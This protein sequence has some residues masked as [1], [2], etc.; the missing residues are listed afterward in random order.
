MSIFRIRFT[1]MVFKLSASFLFLILLTAIPIGWFSFSEQEKLTNA[2]VN[3]TNDAFANFI[4]SSVMKVLSQTRSQVEMV[5][6]HEDFQ[7]MEPSKML[8]RL[9]QLMRKD[10]LFYAAGVY[11]RSKTL[12][13]ETKTFVKVRNLERLFSTSLLH[14]YGMSLFENQDKPESGAEFRVLIHR[15]GEIHGVLIVQLNMRHIQ[16]DLN[17]AKVFM[18]YTNKFADIFILDEKNQV[19]SKSGSSPIVDLSHSHPSSTARSQAYTKN[20]QDYYGSYETPPWQVIFVPKG[21][22]YDQLKKFKTTFAQFILAYI[23]IAGLLGLYAA[24]RISQPLNRLVTSMEKISQG[25]LDT[26]VEVETSDEIGELSQKFED[27]RTNLQEYRSRLNKKIA[28]LQTL[29]HV[30]TIV[31]SQLE[32]SHLLKTILDTVTDVMEAEKGSIM[33]YDSNTELLKI[34]MAKGLD[35][36]VLRKTVLAS[37]ESVAGHVFQTRQPMLV[38]DTLQDETFIRL[39]RLKVSPG[40]MLSVPLV[41]K[42]RSLGVMN[43]SKSRPYSFDEVDLNLF[44]AIANICATAIDNARLYKLAITDEMTGLYL[45]RYF[46]VNMRDLIENSSEPFSLM[47]L[48]IDSFK[49]FNDNFG[50]ACGDRVLIQ[51]ARIIANS[52]RDCDIP[53]R[54]GGEEFAVICPGQT[55]KEAKAPSNRLRKLIHDKPVITPDGQEVQV[56]VSIGIAEYPKDG[57][58]VDAIY[59]ASDQALYR[60]KRE[61]KNCVTLYEPCTP[62][63]KKA[64]TV[65]NQEK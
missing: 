46:Y 18:E 40:T 26:V 5:A 63:T 12:V 10:A 54:L 32:Y 56:A 57:D 45:R 9:K 19:I 38:L 35:K 11:D 7:E 55:S 47:M 50:H 42:E 15:G 60:S 27:M 52:V 48:D 37:G 33:I 62:N 8:S 34:A 13:A 29:Y 58:T 3:K 14:R 24:R 61:G 44:Q 22:A 4:A 51:V 31:T 39:K 64:E 1:R 20:L 59:E 25:N 41:S 17:R 65:G 28:E 23:F 16:K 21:T 43:V 36:E 30:G 49:N 2:Y 6:G 53:C